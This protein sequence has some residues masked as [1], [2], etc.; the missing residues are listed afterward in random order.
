MFVSNGGLALIRL[1]DSR[2]YLL[3]MAERLAPVHVLLS[4]QVAPGELSH[5][6]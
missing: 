3:A 1:V 5:V 4:W 6:S 2:S